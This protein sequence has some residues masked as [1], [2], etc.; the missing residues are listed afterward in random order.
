VANGCGGG[1]VLSLGIPTT[2]KGI[3]FRSRA[4][5]C[6]AAFFDNLGWTWSY[7]PID[8][9]GYIPDFLVQGHDGKQV[10]FEVKGGEIG[11]HA[12]NQFVAKIEESGWRQEAVVVGAEPCAITSDDGLSGYHVAGVIAAPELVGDSTEWDWQSCEFFYCIS[13]GKVSFMN[14]SASW[15]CRLCGA[16]DGHHGDAFDMVK[17]AWSRAKNRVQ[18]RAA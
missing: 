3:R 8:L 10:L 16:P 13:C 17:D 7:E 1:D 6:W 18:W 2:Y 15:H 12:L 5:A 14:P 9:A 4:E 11:T